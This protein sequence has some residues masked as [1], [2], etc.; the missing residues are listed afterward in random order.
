MNPVI[1]ESIRFSS[2]DVTTRTTWVFAEIFDAEGISEVV[3]VTSGNNSNAVAKIIREM[4][5]NIKGVSIS[6]E[7]ELQSLLI[8]T[9]KALETD[10]VL[11]TAMSALRTSI[12]CFQARYESIS[13]TEHLGGTIKDKVPLYA[14]INRSLLGDNRSPTHFAKGAE[15]AVGNGFTTIKCAPFDE[16][17]SDMKLEDIIDASKT[18]LERVRAIRLSIGNKINILVD[19]HS[20]FTL[21]TAPQICSELTSLDVKWFEEPV[22]PETKSHELSQI[23]SVIDLPI[24][25]GESGYGTSFFDNLMDKNSLEI[26]MPDIKFCG[27]VNE[28]IKASLSASKKRKRFSLH[29]PSG[30]VSQLLSAHVTAAASDSMPLEHAVDETDWR[31]ELMFPA[32]E[33]R[34]GFFWIPQGHSI[35]AALNQNI[36]R[37]KGT[38]W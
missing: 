3:E 25:G 26:I 17:T 9:T 24:A 2:I 29:N 28:A 12:S 35:G 11:A 16:V 15:K 30:P 23:A 18:G 33:I 7:S 27:G 19:C 8:L 14:N 10:T 22:A 37:N 21:E 6:G 32:E 5:N 36:M 20:R 34:D 4:V 38:Q 31:A 1:L 13:L